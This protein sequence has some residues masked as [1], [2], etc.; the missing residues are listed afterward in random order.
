VTRGSLHFGVYR[1]TTQSSLSRIEARW[2]S[3]NKPTHTLF[4]S[5]RPTLPQ[6]ESWIQ[7]SGLTCIHHWID[8][9]GEEG[10][11]LTN[12]KA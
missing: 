10:I 8:P 5:R 1:D 4:S 6:V 11:W 3:G 12:R 2:I 7:T 9:K